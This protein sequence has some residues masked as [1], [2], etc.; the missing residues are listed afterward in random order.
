MADL[1]EGLLQ[2]SDGTAPVAGR[3]ATLLASHCASCERTDFPRRPR[4]PR[5]FGEADPVALASGGRVVSSTAVLHQPPDAMIQAPYSIAMVRF[6]SGVEV[7]GVAEGD[8]AVLATGTAVSTEAF[9]FGDHVGFRFV[10]S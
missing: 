10:R 4:C 6:D 3:P 9:A 1:F 8:G 5:C 2:S 7:L